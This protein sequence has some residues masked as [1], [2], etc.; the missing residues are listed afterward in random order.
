MRVR[1]LG[2]GLIWLVTVA[3]ASALVWTVISLTGLRQ[4]ESTLVVP[5]PAETAV[6]AVAGSWRGPVGR[7][8]ATCTGDDIAVGTVVPS[9]GWTAEFKD[10]GPAKLDLEFEAKQEREGKELRLIVRCV[11]VAPQ[12]QIG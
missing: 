5:A 7:V 8:T 12:F 9:A 3:S 1:W 4:S 2:I 11:A 10:R 6:S